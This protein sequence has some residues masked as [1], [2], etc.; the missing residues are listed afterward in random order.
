MTLMYLKFIQIMFW[1]D[2]WY[3]NWAFE[4]K[5]TCFKNHFLNVLKK[6]KTNY[7][8]F[9]GFAIWM[10]MWGKSD[11]WIHKIKSIEF[12]LP[13]YLFATGFGWMLSMPPYSLCH[14]YN[15]RYKSF[16]KKQDICI[17]IYRTYKRKCFSSLPIQEIVC[18][19]ISHTKYII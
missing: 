5:L 15:Y 16:R 8:V 17:P 1:G 19:H 10:N 6:F 3:R 7:K 9:F 13:A 18:N 4:T 11:L 14:L 12:M 2:N